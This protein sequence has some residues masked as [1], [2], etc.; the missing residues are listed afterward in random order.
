MRIFE[1]PNMDNRV[2]TSF[3]GNRHRPGFYLIPGLLADDDDGQ[4]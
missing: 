2:G 4:P 1:D 3:A